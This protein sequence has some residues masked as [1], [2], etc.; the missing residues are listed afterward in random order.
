MK[1]LK[2]WNTLIFQFILLLIAYE[3]NAQNQVL[4]K[5]NGGTHLSPASGCLVNVRAKLNSNQTIPSGQ[6]TTVVFPTEDYDVNGIFNTSS[7]ILTVPLSGYYVITA[8]VNWDNSNTTH[9]IRSIRLV[10]NN[11][12][13]LEQVEEEGSGAMHSFWLV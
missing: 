11:T 3:L 8:S 13:I 1:T 7:G 5:I 2:E 4:T 6:V 10:K 9:G 12:V